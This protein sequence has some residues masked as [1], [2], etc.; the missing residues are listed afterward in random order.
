[1]FQGESTLQAMY[2]PWEKNT[3]FD[4][5][6]IRRVENSHRLGCTLFPG[7][8]WDEQPTSTNAENVWVFSGDL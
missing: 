5:S 2:V 4:A 7:K 8:Y 1:M 3:G 6:E